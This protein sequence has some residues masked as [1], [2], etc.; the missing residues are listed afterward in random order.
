MEVSKKLFYLAKNLTNRV[1]EINVKDM[2]KGDLN[3]VDPDL[4]SA[5]ES[6]KR[7][8]SKNKETERMNNEQ[9]YDIARN[10]VLSTAEKGIRSH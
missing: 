6:F 1:F 3:E 10:I 9:I 4:S 8:L 7:E 2:F 5:F